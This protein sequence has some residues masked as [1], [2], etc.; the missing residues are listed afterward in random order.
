MQVFISYAH[1]DADAPLAL[2]IAERLRA[3]GLTAWLDRASISPSAHTREAIERAARESNHAVFLVSRS[4]LVRDW[5]EWE[6]GL[7]EHRDPATV[8]RVPVL[9]R[10]RRELR[11]PPGLYRHAGFEWLE[12]DPDEDARFWE[13]Y[14]ALLGR[15]PG[16][17]Q[18]WSAEG[19][20]LTPGV[21]PPPPPP[22]PESERPS[23]KCDRA[24]QWTA[25]DTLASSGGN[26]LILV[27][28][29]AGQDHDHFMQR[30]EGH[31][32]PDPPRAIV[33]VAWRGQGRPRS[34]GD[35]RESLAAILRVPPLYLEAELA[36]RLARENLVLL[37]PCIRF[38]FVDSPLVRY[39]STWW[40][41]WL[42]AAGAAG[43]VKCVQ[44]IEWPPYSFPKML[45]RWLSAEAAA[46]GTEK[47]DALGLIRRVLDASAPLLRAIRL[48]ELKDVTRQ[49]LTEFCDLQGLTPPQREWL[50]DRIRSRNARMPIDVFR[51]IDDYYPELPADRRIA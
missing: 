24:R 12:D 39:Y 17:P 46:R 42:K 32:R 3:A 14:C 28:G 33:P 30:I 19:R 20:A 45:H 15:E 21:D 27:P 1:T 29:A 34:E 6:L 36:G 25:T 10:P 23:L 49:D 2:R 41:E 16:L 44:P 50:L 48:A 18:H 37:H 4:W 35:F 22:P 47:P 9:R 8:R 26:E 31:F 11:L 38:R 7:F 51:A 40:P 13:L 5:T 43:N